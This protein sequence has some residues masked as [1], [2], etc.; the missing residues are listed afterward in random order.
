[1]FCNDLR[2]SSHP[3]HSH[4]HGKIS[5]G[6]CLVED[7]LMEQMT[8]Q[9]FFEKTHVF[10]KKL[11]TVKPMFFLNKHVFFKKIKTIFLNKIKIFLN[12]PKIF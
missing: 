11:N 1:M 2:P 10:Q 9:T 4:L 3:I 6:K 7:F 8:D 5:P 12:K